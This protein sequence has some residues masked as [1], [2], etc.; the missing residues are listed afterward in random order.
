MHIHPHWED[1]HYDG[2]QWAIDVK[3]YKLA[4]FEKSDINRIVKQYKEALESITNKP[5]KSYRAGGWCLQPFSKVHQAFVENG[6]QLDSTVFGGGHFESEHY[7]YDF[8]NIPN[9]SRWQFE[10]DLCIEQEGGRFLEIPIGNQKIGPLF[11]WQLFLW[12][13]LDPKNHKPIGDGYPI[14]TPGWRKKVLTSTSNNCVSLDGYFAKRLSKA[15]RL[16]QRAGK[17][18]LVVIGHPKACTW[19]SLK[20]LQ[21]FIE[22]HNKSH[23]FITFNDVIE[24]L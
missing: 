16:Q 12:G 18:D 11:F 2:D 23:K 4:D 1:S 19:Y 22:K 20:K 17:E 3:R 9:K 14:P 15:A 6:L 8:R 24:S 21:Q 5:V 10:D 13:R 7:F